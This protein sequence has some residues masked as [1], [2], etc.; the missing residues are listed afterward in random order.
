MSKTGDFDHPLF[1]HKCVGI[2]SLVTKSGW[3]DRRVQDSP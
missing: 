1:A 3:W 2:T